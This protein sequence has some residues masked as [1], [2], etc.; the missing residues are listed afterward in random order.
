[1][2]NSDKTWTLLVVLTLGLVA[3]AA[4][5]HDDEDEDAA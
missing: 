5:A 1:M 4:V 2:T 3:T